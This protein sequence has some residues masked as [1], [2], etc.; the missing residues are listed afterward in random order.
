MIQSYRSWR[1]TSVRFAVLASEAGQLNALETLNIR[2]ER[3]IT[4]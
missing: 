3:S 2:G 1:E 4:M